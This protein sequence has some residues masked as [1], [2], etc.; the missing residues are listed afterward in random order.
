MC[1]G[2]LRSDV[3]RSAPIRCAAVRSDPM[4][5]RLRRSD[6]L[7]SAPIRCAAVRSDPMC[8][9]PLQTDELPSA[10]IRGRA[11]RACAYRPFA[12]QRCCPF[13][14]LAKARGRDRK[15]EDSGVQSSVEVMFGGQA[16]DGSLTTGDLIAGVFKRCGLEVYTYK[17]FPS[18]IR[19]GHTNYVIRACTRTG[20]RHGRLRRCAG[21][22]RSRSGRSR[23]SRRTAPRRFHHLRLHLGCD[24]R[25]VAAPDVVW[26]ELPLGK[27]AKE[28]LGPEIVRNTISLGVL[29]ALFGIDPQIVRAE[30]RRRLRTQGSSSRRP[31]HSRDRGRRTRAAAT[32]FAATNGYALARAPERERLLMM[33]NDAIALGALAAGCRF[34]A[35][36]PITP[37]T[38]ILEWM[39]REM[40]RFGGVA[41]QAEDELAAITMV[42]GAA[43]AGMRAMTATSG[44]GQALMTEGDR[45][46]RRAGDSRSSSSNARAPDRRPECRRRPSRAIST[47]SS[48][49]GTARFRASCSR[50]ERCDESF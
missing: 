8:C 43:W 10:P 50:R 2:P 22:L 46:G 49:A 3:L 38:D 20:L 35:G 27:I 36:Y 14:H 32:S 1:C 7:Q 34:V 9:G 19:G 4:C 23:T 30:V 5:C 21:R 33:G 47:M 11:T 13:K 18:R 48:T 29:G 6:V 26:Y 39:A 28:D 40:P 25:R 16:G 12:G 44:P 17:D 31:E 37:A 41:V 42:L 15:G 24:A 45:A